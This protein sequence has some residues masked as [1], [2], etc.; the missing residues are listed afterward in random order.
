MNFLCL[1]PDLQEELLLLPTV[2]RGRAP[3]TEKLLRPIAATPCWKK[4]RRMWQLL[5]GASGAS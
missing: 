4:Q 5:L 3:L 1:A 2:E